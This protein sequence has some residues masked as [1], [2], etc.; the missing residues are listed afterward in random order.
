MQ[1]TINYRGL[2]SE[3]GEVRH[4]LLL[5]V[6]LEVEVKHM[7]SPICV[8]IVFSGGKFYYFLNKCLRYFRRVL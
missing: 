4:Q 5:S 3:G 1:I 2:K 7:V 6:N 8:L